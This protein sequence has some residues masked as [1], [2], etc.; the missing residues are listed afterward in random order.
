MKSYRFIWLIL[1]IT[2]S[3]EN[4]GTTKDLNKVEQQLIQAP[5]HVKAEANQT[6]QEMA[7]LELYKNVK[8]NLILCDNFE[9]TI[10]IDRLVDNSIRYV[11]WKK[12]NSTSNAPNLIIK[13]GVSVK[14]TPADRQEYVFSQED[15][16][17]AV[18]KIISNDA[19][20]I[21]H[22]FLEIQDKEGKENYAW[23]MRDLTHHKYTDIR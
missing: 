4:S 16:N 20:G 9:F 2:Y 21:N 5:K 14:N 11:C 13:N 7:L 6:E 23:K 10:R 1:L 15:W 22:I 17:Y 12:P 3:C 19:R 18:E 8:A